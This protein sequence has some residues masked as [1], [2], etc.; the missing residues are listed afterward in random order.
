MANTLY[1]NNL[2]TTGCVYYNLVIEM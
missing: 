2:H 1:Y